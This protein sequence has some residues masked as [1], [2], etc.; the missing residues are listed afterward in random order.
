MTSMITRTKPFL[1]ALALVL[2]AMTCTLPAATGA[3]A[4]VRTVAGP[5]RGRVEHGVDAFL[6]IPFAQPPVGALRWR[7]PQPVKHWSTVRN[8]TEYGPDCM[9][10]PF[11]GDAAP[12]GNTPKEDCLYLNVWRPRPLPKHALPVMVWIYGG[13]FVNG[14]SSPAVYSGSHFAR[15]RIVFVSF[16]YRL[17]R[18]GFFAFPALLK[19]QAGQPLGNYA[20]LDQIAALKWVQKNIANFGGDPSQVTIFGESAGGLSVNML[21]NSPLAH[22]LF[23]RAMV[24]SGGGRDNLQPMAGLTHGS[25][26]LPSAVQI[27]ENFARQM[28]IQGTGKQALAALR[29]L[30]AGKIVNGINMATMFAQRDTYS[31]PMVDGMIVKKPDEQAYKSGAEA[32][33]PIVTGANSL[34]IGFM[35]VHSKQ[36]LWAKFG[37]N[38]AAAKAAFDPH[39]DKSLRE[40]IQRVGSEIIMIEPA[41]FVAAAVSRIGQ[42]A[43]VYRFSYVATCLR[44]KL[45]GAPHATEIPFAFDT[46]R[47]HYGKDTSAQDEQIA[48]LMNAYWSN[49]AKAG[50]P[51]GAGLPHWPR[52]TQQGDGMMNFTEHGAAGERDPWGKQLDLV[53]RMQK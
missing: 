4:V 34:D 2:G 51:N 19:E 32:H 26:Q 7:A 9:Q 40:L 25:A 50:N 20:F 33:V 49:F 22:G 27:G 6:G 10:L 52:Y 3:G 24:E 13:G 48:R 29:N 31:G 23:E 46:V 44:K 35:N 1:A 39:G 42:P 21:M 12:L 47:A 41:R 45:P 5:V 14:G 18:F 30:P 15:H 37:V 11:P 8:A 16:N 17:G 43:Y 38:A 53:E 28:G 36:E